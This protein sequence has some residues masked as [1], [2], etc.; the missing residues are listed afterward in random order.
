MK[1]QEKLIQ[2]AARE[3]ALLKVSEVLTEYG[4]GFHYEGSTHRVYK[5]TKPLPWKLVLDLMWIHGIELSYDTYERSLT[6]GQEYL[7]YIYYLKSY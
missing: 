1:D 7:M 3:T 2:K 4:F 6:T 5:G